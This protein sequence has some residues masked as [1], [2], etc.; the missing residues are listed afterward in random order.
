MQGM[1]SLSKF[2]HDVKRELI[3]AQGK[4]PGE[5]FELTEVNLEVAFAVETDAKGK[6]KLVVFEANAGTSS[7]QTHTVTLR[8][9]PLRREPKSVPVRVKDFVLDATAREQ[10]TMQE[11]AGG[12]R[13]INENDPIK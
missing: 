4:S 12:V 5:F 1:I 13:Y 6:A 3:E 2:I 10:T 9:T 7:S 8:L 11:W